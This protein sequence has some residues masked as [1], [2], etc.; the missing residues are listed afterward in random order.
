MLS[1]FEETE[2][3]RGGGGEEE[4]ERG[5]GRG[6]G[7]EEKTEQEKERERERE[8]EREMLINV[9]MREESQNDEGQP[10][11]EHDPI[12]CLQG[13]SAYHP[14]C[15]NSL[16]HMHCAGGELTYFTINTTI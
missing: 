2:R 13:A 5:G 4:R 16:W 6:G 15:S 3:R 1:G 8:R 7:R 11:V 12:T 10:N 14:K 9:I